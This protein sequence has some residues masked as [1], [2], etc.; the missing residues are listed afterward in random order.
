MTKAKKDP[1]EEPIVDQ[2]DQA[3]EELKSDLQRVQADF[4]NFRRRIEGERGELI[5]VAK[6]AVI[7]QLLPLFDNLDRAL[8]HAPAELSGNA[9]VQGVEHV[10]KQVVETLASLGIE[11][12]GAV[13]DEFDPNMHEAIAHVGEGSTIA[14]VLSKGYRNDQKVIRP[15]M[16]K[17]G[18]LN[19]ENKS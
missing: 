2:S 16:V 6:A 3:L 11:A 10:A 17:I 14:E 1:I 12:Y 5:E 9:W 7:E 19:K 15:A 13:G 8:T 4:V 18:E